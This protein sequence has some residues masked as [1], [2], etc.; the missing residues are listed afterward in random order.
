MADEGARCHS[1]QPTANKRGYFRYKQDADRLI[2]SVRPQTDV[3]KDGIGETPC[4]PFD[5]IRCGELLR[6]HGLDRQRP[7]CTLFL[8]S[9]SEESRPTQGILDNGILHFVQD[10]ILGNM[11]R[12]VSSRTTEVTDFD[13]ERNSHE[14]TQHIRT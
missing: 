8:R 4:V 10:D 1:E 11:P 12:N 13:L 6:V 7:P 2:L 9:T 5:T 14:Y 3:S